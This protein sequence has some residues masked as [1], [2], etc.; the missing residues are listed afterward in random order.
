MPPSA[1]SWS[2]VAPNLATVRSRIRDAAAVAGRDPAD[3]QL[4]AV[5]K[6]F[7]LNAI[8]AAHDAGQTLFGENRVQEAIPKIEAL[9]TIDARSGPRPRVHLIGH[10]QT[11]KA[12]QAGAF[13]MIES[14]DSVRLAVALDRRL[15]HPIPI[16]LEINVA[17]ETSKEGF[18]PT[19]L[20]EA[21]AA[22]E[23]LTNIG[24]VGL[25][26]VAPLVADPEG[27][28]PIFHELRRLRDDA[29]HHHADL[30]HLS[31]G[32]TNDFAVAIQE[33]ATIVRIGRA[34]FGDR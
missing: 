16:L 7:P 24:V 25:M 31:M 20:T 21:L 13:D 29:R 19:D 15:A 9:A 14:V 8:L 10:L 3:V 30:Q 27:A 32:M 34:I 22:I 26:T 17:G 11:N 33:G 5:S 12:K 1:E 4:V 23:P 6:T 18:A 28:R 2:H